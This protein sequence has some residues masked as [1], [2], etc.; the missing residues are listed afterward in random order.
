MTGDRKKI[1]T[2]LIQY[3]YIYIYIYIKFQFQ[4]LNDLFF[5]VQVHVDYLYIV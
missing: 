5:C 1:F 3:I 4:Y 2:G